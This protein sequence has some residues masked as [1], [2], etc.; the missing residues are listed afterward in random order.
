MRSALSGKG[1]FERRGVVKPMALFL[2]CWRRRRRSRY[3]S[4]KVTV[5]MSSSCN[6]R[7]TICIAAIL[8]VR[9]LLARRRIPK[10]LTQ[11]L[12]RY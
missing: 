8:D 10:E 3:S 2:W 9:L 12:R 4:G 6:R 11:L 5:G 7:G 1:G